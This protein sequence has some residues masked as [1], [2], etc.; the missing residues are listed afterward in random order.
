MSPK[1]SQMPAW[2]PPCP[3]ARAYDTLPSIMRMVRRKGKKEKDMQEPEGTTTAT[4]DSE[5]MRLIERYAE[6]K[7]MPLP[8]AL[9]SLIAEELGGRGV[10]DAETPAM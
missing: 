6:R 9:R 5:T 4:L 3:P 8:Y 10:R 7:G 1:G 2:K